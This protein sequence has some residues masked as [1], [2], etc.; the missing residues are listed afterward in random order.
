MK[1]PKLKGCTMELLEK[2]VIENAKQRFTMRLEEENGVEELWIRAN[3][4]HT[5][6]VRFSSL[7]IN[8]MK[9]SRCF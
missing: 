7:T 8:L 5:V 3:Q 6:A 4:G 2:I 1:R 9:Y